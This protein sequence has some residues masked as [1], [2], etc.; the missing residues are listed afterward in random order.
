MIHY[1]KGKGEV[2]ILYCNTNVHICACS[3]EID[4]LLPDEPILHSQ[5]MFTTSYYLL[6]QSVYT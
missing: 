6:V 1:D 2:Y 3:R 4:L 5:I